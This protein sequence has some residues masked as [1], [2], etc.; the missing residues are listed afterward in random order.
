VL[1]LLKRLWLK[2]GALL[3]VV[4]NPIALGFMYV[5]AI[6]PVGHVRI[7][8]TTARK[9]LLFEIRRKEFRVSTVCQEAHD[10]FRGSVCYSPE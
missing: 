10:A 9:M 7:L 2:L 6:I 4:V 5:T 3:S 8:K 1:A